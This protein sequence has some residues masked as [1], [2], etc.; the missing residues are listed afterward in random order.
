M[1]REPAR[2][3]GLFATILL[4]LVGCASNK[5]PEDALRLHE[6]SIELRAKQ[7]RVFAAES[8]AAIVAASVA[9]L[10]DIEY[11]LD[12]IEGP[13]GLL[14]ASKKV[15]ADYG[16]EKAFLVALDLLCIAASGG[17]C[18]LFST[19]SDDQVISMTM[20]VLPS[21]AK[22]DDFVVRVTAQYVLSDK[23]ATV[24]KRATI[25]D[26]EIYQKI[27]A[28]LSKSLFLGGAE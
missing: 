20:V 7:S 2:T 12:L 25:E 1:K 10:Q 14:T 28:N 24:R 21:L 26:A 4:L 9:V 5:V 22:P 6:S 23:S 19:A 16:P 27:F 11:N 15:D 13:L 8:E 3:T 18:G 17:D